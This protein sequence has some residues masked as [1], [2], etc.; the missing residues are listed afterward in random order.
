ML[1][2]LLAIV[3]CTAFGAAETA[4]ALDAQELRDLPSVH[5][6]SKCFGVTSQF[7]WQSMFMPIM[8]DGQVLT[9]IGP[10]NIKPQDRDSSHVA[11]NIGWSVD[12]D[13]FARVGP[14]GHFGAAA[15]ALAP[16]N[17]YKYNQN[18]PFGALLVRTS[19]G[20]EGTFRDTS[21]PILIPDQ[22]TFEFRI[23]DSDQSLGNNGGYLIL[24]IIDVSHV[25]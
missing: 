23:N 3:S 5:E 17:Q 4:S 1:R 14:D 25:K 24:C 19:S 9:I 10:D 15:Q 2:K 8:S 18:A 11:R 20:Q 16:Y 13:N 6:Y 12:I 22:G 7:G 21:G